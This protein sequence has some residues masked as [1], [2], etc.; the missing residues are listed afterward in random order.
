MMN[1]P[2]EGWGDMGYGEREAWRRGQMN[3]QEENERALE[4]LELGQ[5]VETPDGWSGF[6]AEK[7]PER[8]T[9]YVETWDT[10]GTYQARLLEPGGDGR[11][12]GGSDSLTGGL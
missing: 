10:G 8:G 12:L 5:T 2:P 3:R 6:V 11:D 7:H 1:D 4:R 9:A